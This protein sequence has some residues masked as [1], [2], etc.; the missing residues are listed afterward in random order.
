MVAAALDEVH[1]KTSVFFAWCGS[2][3]SSPWVESGAR[4]AGAR[5]ELGSGYS[6]STTVTA[7]AAPSVWLLTM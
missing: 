3:D 7:Q 4:D 1:R 6:V 5:Q 2:D